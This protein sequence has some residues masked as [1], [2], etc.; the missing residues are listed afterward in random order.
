ME[1]VKDALHVPAKDSLRK[2]KDKRKDSSKIDNIE[3]AHRDATEMSKRE[4][5]HHTTSKE[6]RQ[7][8]DRIHQGNKFL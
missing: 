4:D 5:Q 7:I 1:R 8:F 3:R 6:A 2:L